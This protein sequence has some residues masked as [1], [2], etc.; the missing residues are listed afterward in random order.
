[1]IRW[2]TGRWRNTSSGQGGKMLKL[3]FSYIFQA[4]LAILH[5]NIKGCICVNLGHNV[6]KNWL[7]LLNLLRNI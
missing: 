5:Q 3:L 1:M 4:E 6:V 2:L 7:S